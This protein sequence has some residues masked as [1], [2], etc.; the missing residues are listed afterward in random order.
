MKPVAFKTAFALCFLLLCVVFTTAA[1][2]PSV[3]AVAERAT[4]TIE[5]ADGNCSGTAVSAYVIMTAAHCFPDDLAVKFKISGREAKAL[6]F[7]RDG[8]DH[9]LIKVNIAFTYTAS[10]GNTRMLKGD[11]IF[12]FGNPGIWQLFRTGHVAGY[13]DTATVIDVNGWRGDSGAAIF[14]EQGHIVGI[15]SAGILNDIFKLMLA[16]PFAFT[17]EQYKDFGL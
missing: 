5:M 3:Y 8:N 17:D 11:K 12:Y 15:V 2:K 13:K 7:A 9:V 14:N 1:R 6:K 10:I 16:Y 4:H